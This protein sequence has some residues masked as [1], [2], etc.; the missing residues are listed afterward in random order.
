[1]ANG[2]LQTEL[3]PPAASLAYLPRTWLDNRRVLMI[4]FTPNADAPPQNIYILD[5]GKGANQQTTDLQQ[6]VTV[7]SPCWD[8]DSSYDGTKLFISQCTP[9]Q[10]EGSSTVSVKST[11]GNVPPTTFFTSSTLAI[12]SVRVIDPNSTYLLATATNMGLR[13]TGY[14][15][16]N[17]LYKLKTHGS[18]TPLPLT[19][20][21]SR[22][23][24]P[25]H[26]FPHS[27]C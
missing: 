16:H 21:A 18:T 13:L 8:F 3:V 7:G 26:S 9:G 24:S 15:T 2:T 27:F 12:T 25:S 10:P 1:M 14:T 4:G 19:S 6:A 23:I 22:H 17:A 20:R 5:T 11:T